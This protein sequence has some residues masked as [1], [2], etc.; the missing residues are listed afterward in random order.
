MA[1]H[2]RKSRRV[3]TPNDAVEILRDVMKLYPKEHFVLVCLD[4]KGY[5]ILH[6]NFPGDIDHVNINLREITNAILRVTSS[7]VIVAHNHPNGN[8]NPSDQ[9]IAATRAL[10]GVLAPLGINLVD[11]IIFANDKF[12]SFTF[13]G[14]LD[15]LMRENRAFATNKNYKE[16]QL[17][18]PQGYSADTTQNS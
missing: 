12:Y 4:A 6:Q 15:V 11:H 3:T 13:N 18:R 1:G 9:D 17:G 10:V 8:A 5:M 16:I 14:V 7:A 2:Q